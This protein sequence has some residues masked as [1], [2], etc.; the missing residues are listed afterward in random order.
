[1]RRRRGAGDAGGGNAGGSGGSSSG[2][3]DEIDVA[4]SLQYSEVMVFWDP[5]D[6]FSNEIMAMQNM[7]ETLLH[8]DPL[9]DDF[10]PVLATSWDRSE[11]GLTWTFHLR[12]GVKF[13][14]GKEMTS[15]DVKGSIERTIQRGQG[16][17]FIWD[18]LDRIETP[19]DYTVV[20]HLKYPAPL[21]LIVSAGYSAYIFD[22]DVAD[23]EWFNAGNDAGTGPYT[24]ESWTQGEQLVLTRF[25]DYW[26]GWNDPRQW[27]KVVFRIV[28]EAATR[29]QLM[30]TGQGDFTYG[31][32]PEMVEALR[33]NANLQVVETPSFQN[34]LGMLN[35]E[36][37]PLDDVRVRKAL[38]HAFPYQQ[39]V[40]H[41][42]Q[43]T[44][45]PARG[46]IPYGMWGHGEDLPQPGYDLDEARRLLAEAGYP[47]GGFSLVLTYT[48]GDEVERRAAELYQVEL[49][50]AGHRPG[51]PGHALGAAVG[52]GPVA[53][54][55]AAAGHPAVLLVARPGASPVVAGCAVQEP[56]RDPLQ[57]ELLQQ[58]R[59]RRA[60]GAWGRR[61]GPRPRAGRGD[62]HRGAAAPAGGR[63]GAVHLRPEVRAGDQQPPGRVRGQPGLPARG[64]VVRDVQRRPLTRFR[65]APAGAAPVGRAWVAGLLSSGG[66]SCRRWPCWGWPSSPSWWRGWS[67]PI[68]PPAGW[69][70][71]ATAEQIARARVELGLDQPLWRQLITH[72][73]ALAVGDW[74]RSIITHQPVIRDI[75]AH[76]PTSLV[77][78]AA[79]TLLAVALGIPL[80]VVSAAARNRWPDHLSPGAGHRGWCPIPTFWLAMI[81]QFVAGA[82]GAGCCPSAGR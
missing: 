49:G 29:R 77:L 17:S 43:G 38:A 72:M 33:S 41:V 64:A 44:A 20:F 32:P 36:K 66:S 14:T 35:T 63:G 65:A 47:D 39:V 8:Y 60:G 9:A 31:L 54:P 25:D 26:G 55:P 23:E 40:D 58:S 27:D 73:A 22:V 5:S 50:V 52:P 37:A 19:D 78:V 80:G 46:P 21:D 11:D 61:G 82:R 6:S 42:M 45:R 18:P 59:V 10:K 75:A 4:V 56:G 51:D 70:P 71:H 24:V 79:G 81:L 13:H 15:A 48:A 34:L 57:P 1:M 76:L 7:Y 67:R 62:L 3:A 30:E 53:G 74:G 68:P 28:P 2:Q 12:Q 16:A 69:V